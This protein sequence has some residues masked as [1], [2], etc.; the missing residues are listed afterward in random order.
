MAKPHD[1]ESGGVGRGETSLVSLLY[2][3]YHLD[4][5]ENL[6]PLKDTHVPFVVVVWRNNNNNTTVFC[7]CCLWFF[8]FFLRAIYYSTIILLAAAGCCSLRSPPLLIDLVI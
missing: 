1:G 6:R 4:G 7:F 8:F 2:F 3:P 5:L